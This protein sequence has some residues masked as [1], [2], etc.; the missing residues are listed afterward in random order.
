MQ[1]I[2]KNFIGI[3]ALILMLFG[4][5]LMVI[6]SNPSPREI[7]SLIGSF[8]VVTGLFIGLLAEKVNRIG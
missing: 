5:I 3:G 8:V 1:F 6:P 2:K 4:L 7:L